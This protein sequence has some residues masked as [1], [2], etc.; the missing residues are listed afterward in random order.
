MYSVNEEMEV[1]VVEDG[2]REERS[3]TA[4]RPVQEVRAM[5][6]QLKAEVWCLVDG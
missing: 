6:R 2:G 4:N 5:I 3:T 1:V